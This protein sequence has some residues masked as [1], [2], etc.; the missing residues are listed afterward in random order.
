MKKNDEYPLFVPS[1]VQAAVKTKLKQNRPEF[2]Y[3]IYH[4]WYL[5]DRILTGPT[6][7][8]DTP[9]FRPLNQKRKKEKER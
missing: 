9:D 8:K 6:F 3:D 5:L 2:K 1:S 7:K 4:F